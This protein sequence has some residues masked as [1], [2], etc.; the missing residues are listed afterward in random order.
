MS[1]L[2]TEPVRSSATT[3]W[4][5][6]VATSLLWG[7]GGL[8]SKAL[9]ADGVDPF[10]V[11]A[12]PFAAGAVAAWLVSRRVPSRSILVTGLLLGMINTAGPALFFNLGYETL[13]AGIVTLLI[14][15]GP[16]VTA[17]TAHFAFADERFNRAKGAGLAISVAGVAVL[18]TAQATGGDGTPVGV[19]LVLTGALLSGVTAVWARSVA[20][21]HG[22][23]NLV[24]SQLTGAALMPL[25]LAAVLG[26]QLVPSGGFEPSHL[27]WLIV[28]GTVASFVG[29]RMVMR[30]NEIGTAG[31]VSLIG[32]LLPV[33]GVVGG[34]VVFDEPITP[35]VVVG[36]ALILVGILT[37]GRAAGKPVRVIRS[38]G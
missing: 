13:P 22:A 12:G 31:Q 11:T 30:A 6:V 35:S 15:F 19:A 36:G 2:T 23:K 38:A 16:V 8:I 24:P 26:R 18:S 21:R 10:T 4:L 14:A 7:G 27:V 33:V 17:I 9:V 37:V 1:A 20:V 5:L 34:A 3:V 25:L 32:Y 29:F 28:I